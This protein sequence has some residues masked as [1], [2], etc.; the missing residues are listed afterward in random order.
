MP[1]GVGAG[2]Q[3]PLDGG[4]GEHL[5]IGDE[6]VDVVDAAVEVVLD[7]VEVAV[8]AVGD[9]GRDVALG[10]AVDVLGGHVEGPDDRVEGVVDALDDAEV[11]ALVAAGVGA[12]GQAP[13]DGGGGEHL[14]VCDER[15]DGVDAGVEVV[16]DLVEVAVVAVGDAGRDVALG[17]AVDVLGGHVEG[18]DD[19]VEGVVDAL[20]DAE[21]VA[22]VLGGVGAGCELALHG[23]HAEHV[24]VCDERVDGVDAAVE[25][26]LDGVEVTVVGVG[27][28]RGDVSLGDA[29]DVVGGHV[30]GP[31]HRIEAV[32][33]A[34]DDLLVVAL[35][36]AGVGA[37]GELAL[38]R[39]HR[40]HL[41][42]GDEGGEGFH[43]L[44]EGRQQLILLRQAPDLHELGQ[45]TQIPHRD[46][47]HDR[48]HALVVCAHPLNVVVDEGFLARELLERC[49]EVV[50]C[51]LGHAGHRHLLDR[52]VRRDQAVDVPGHRP[53]D[54]RVAVRRH[55][56]VNVAGLVLNVHGVQVSCQVLEIV[57]T[58]IQVVLE[59]AEVAF[60][61]ILDVWRNVALGDVVDVL[62]GDVEGRD[63]RCEH[64]VHEF[65]GRA[66]GAV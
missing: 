53:I 1:G 50:L 66:L 4:G 63:H 57:A 41:G 59:R 55:R 28:L 32:V 39:R 42:V 40:E 49:I 56:D 60:T 61:G 48:Y 13:V 45:L 25:V 51:E 14:G 54:A 62:G 34:L 5:G 12:G 2:G 15:V 29:I 43:C 31:D 23:G 30:E 18:P 26:V 44:D 6:G 33:D 58:Q 38:D 22:L 9:A 20:D 7:L 10:D 64:L 3:A 8:V 16:L 65:E 47:A 11:V 35:V 17:D 46:V 27:D 37:G 24:G 21:V 52:D 19:R 36:L